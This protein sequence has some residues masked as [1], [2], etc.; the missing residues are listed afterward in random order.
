MD[1]PPPA[2]MRFDIDVV[3]TFIAVTESGSVKAAATRVARSPAAVSI[4]MKKLEWLVSAPVFQG[5][6][7]N[8]EG[9]TMCPRRPRL[10]RRQELTCGSVSQPHRQRRPDWQCD[11]PAAGQIKSA[12]L[13]LAQ[14]V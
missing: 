7:G 13:Q 12:C 11:W 3:K 10:N 8:P 5:V 14:P 6:D 2:S 9:V 1:T 4:Q